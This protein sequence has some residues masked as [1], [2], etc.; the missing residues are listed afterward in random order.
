MEGTTKTIV[1]VTCSTVDGTAVYSSPTG[2]VAVSVFYWMDGIAAALVDMAVVTVNTAVVK[3]FGASL[4]NGVVG[5]SCGVGAMAAE[6]E[7]CICE[8]EDWFGEGAVVNPAAIVTVVLCTA[9]I[10]GVVGAVV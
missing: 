2:V 1:L 3:V 6:A 9:W 10:G 4:D 7:T 5:E 8:R